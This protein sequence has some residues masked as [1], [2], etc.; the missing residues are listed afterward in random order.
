[1]VLTDCLVP[2]DG[3]DR[4]LGTI[5]FTKHEVKY[6]FVT[7][8]HRHHKILIMIVIMCHEKKMEQ[9]QAQNYAHLE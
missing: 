7:Y 4:L 3:T 1:M 2:S 9:R 6:D 5:R 8:N